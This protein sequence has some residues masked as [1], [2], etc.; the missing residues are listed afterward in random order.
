MPK[1]ELRLRTWLP[2]ERVYFSETGLYYIFYLGDNRSEQWEG[3]YR[4]SQRFVI[5]TSAA[6]YAVN[7]FKDTG[8]THKEYVDKVTNKVARTQTDQAPVSDITFSKRIVDD[9]LYLD[10][11]VSS[12]NPL[13]PLS[14]PIDYDFTLKVTRLGSVRITGRHDGFPGY[15]FWRKIGTRTPELIW[16]HDPRDTGETL[17]SLYGEMEHSVDKGLS[18]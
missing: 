9:I 10:C 12:S 8:I 18:A 1:L 11:R 5:D 15:E 14:P 13:E 16:S 7:D 3:T 2:P 6:D 4:T 17:A